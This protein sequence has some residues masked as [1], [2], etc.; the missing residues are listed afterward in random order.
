VAGSASGDRFPLLPFAGG[1]AGAALLLGTGGAYLALTA[2]YDND[3]GSL[4]RVP[5][6][7]L[8]V[9]L[10]GLPLVAATGGWLLAGR[11]PPA[12]ARQPLE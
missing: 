1:L 8:T 6:P 12:L 5:L 2:G 11:Q 4:S 3:L 7:Q 10:A 9:I